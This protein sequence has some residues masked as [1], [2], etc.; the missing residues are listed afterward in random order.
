MGVLRSAHDW[1]RADPDRWASFW[2]A[3]GLTVG[4]AVVRWMV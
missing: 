1:L 4:G 2:F 3:V